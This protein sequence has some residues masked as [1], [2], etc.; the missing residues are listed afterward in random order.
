[1]C[2]CVAELQVCVCVAVSS[3]ALLFAYSTF[4]CLANC[5]TLN[6]F[7]IYMAFNSHSI[8]AIISIFPLAIKVQHLQIARCVVSTSPST[9]LFHSPLSQ[10]LIDRLR[11]HF[12]GPSYWADC[13]L[14]QL[15]THSTVRPS[16]LPSLRLSACVILMNVLC[17]SAAT[18]SAC[19]SA[20]ATL[21]LPGIIAV[22]HIFSGGLK[23]KAEGRKAQGLPA[24]ERRAGRCVL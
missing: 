18:A 24:R 14:L 22:F 21:P 4:E 9:P 17:A 11:S 3:Y 20:S 19:V 16:F 6:K 23:P 10:S 13:Q 12:V 8:Y 15:R 7:F 5:T 2:V 1:M